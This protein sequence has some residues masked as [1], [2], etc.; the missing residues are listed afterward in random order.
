[1]SRAKTV[2]LASNNLHVSIQYGKPHLE[3]QKISCKSQDNKSLFYRGVEISKG[4]KRVHGKEIPGLKR[5]RFCLVILSISFIL[6]IVCT[7]CALFIKNK[8]CKDNP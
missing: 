7:G 4:S 5:G 1:M 8:G 3:K 2:I 6:K